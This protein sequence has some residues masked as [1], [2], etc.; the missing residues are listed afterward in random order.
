MKKT[1][2]KLLIF[3]TLLTLSVSG[4]QKDSFELDTNEVATLSNDS[5]YNISYLING[6]RANVSL[7]DRNA[8][9]EFIR[10][11]TNLSYTG[12]F[13]T[14]IN[15]DDSS[16]MA[17]KDVVKFET[18]DL[19]EM[20]NWIEKMLLDGYEVSWGYDKETGSFR[21]TATKK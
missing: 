21:G 5:Q 15:N 17:T 19:D 13:I 12:D 9:L 7:K 4:C 10:E 20:A 8:L 6:N 18:K 1:K 16:E 11:L 3:S 2:I 14:I